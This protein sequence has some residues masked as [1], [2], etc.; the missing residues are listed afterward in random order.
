MGLYLAIW[1]F[2]F[3]VTAARDPAPG[4]LRS[5]ADAAN[6]ECERVPVDVAVERRP[7][8]VPPVDPR[9]DL[10]SREV[11]I[12]TEKLM[13]LD[14]RDPDDEA[15]LTSLGATAE[16]FAALAATTRPEL[17]HATWL[18][19]SH[20]ADPQVSAKLSFA[21]KN[22][23]MQQGLQVS[24]RTPILGF[25][26]VSV[27]ARMPPLQAWPAACTRYTDTGSLGPDDALLAH[28]VLDPRESIVHAGVCA[29]GVWTWLG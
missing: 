9:G 4:L 26:D 6:M 8:A 24:D 21:T 14:L 16:D 1:T 29:Q 19:D 10:V 28:V 3:T 12:C 13:P 23:L 17:A 22:A 11:L 2:W 20:T 7:G 27:I 18:V 25:D 15:I 5:R